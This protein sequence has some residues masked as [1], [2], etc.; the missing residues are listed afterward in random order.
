M[1]LDKIS[2]GFF[3][4]VAGQ[5]DEI[6]IGRSWSDVVRTPPSVVEDFE[7]GSAGAAIHGKDGGS[8]WG[9]PW[10]DPG[11]NPPNHPY[12]QHHADVN[13]QFDNPGYGWNAVNT[14]GAIA[15]SRSTSSSDVSYTAYRQF[16]T[17]L[18]GTVWISGLAR[19][20]TDDGSILLWLEPATSG[21]SGANSI[22]FFEHATNSSVWIKYNNVASFASNPFNSQMNE[23]HTYLYLAK[24][25]MN[26]SAEGHDRVT[27]WIKKESDDIS[28]EGALG[29]PL[30]SREG[31]DV[32]GSTFDYIGFSFNRTDAYF[33]ALRVGSSFE[34]VTSVPEPSGFLLCWTALGLC[35][36]AT[37]R[38]RRGTR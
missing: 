28:S 9:T 32:F 16:D 26:Y 29:S 20:A 7:Y 8:R 37:G 38:G 2:V 6:R 22:G 33:D 15:N 12:V 17:P 13:L 31:A 14:E 18:D 27:Y 1:N 3:S 23:D 30:F 24:I 5:V 19:A 11:T 25:D 34:F 4:G 35:T 21:T 10:N 36:A